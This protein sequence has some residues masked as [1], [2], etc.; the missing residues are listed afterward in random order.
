MNN[1]IFDVLGIFLVL[2]FVGS[3]ALSAFLLYDIKSGN[4]RKFL[5]SDE[6]HDRLT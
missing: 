6:E 3:I 1:A 2:L 4:Y 5:V